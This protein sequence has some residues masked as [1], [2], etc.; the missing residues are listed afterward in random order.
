MFRARRDP[1]D[2]INKH[3]IYEVWGDMVEGAAEDGPM[4]IEAIRGY[5]ESSSLAEYFNCQVL[6]TKQD[7]HPF[8]ALQWDD[9]VVDIDARSFGAHLD[10]YAILALKR[11]LLDSPDPL[12][13][14]ADLEGWQRRDLQ[15]F[16]TLLKR[17][18]D[19]ALQMLDEGRV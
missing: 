3:D 11:G 6:E 4:V 19:E 14:I 17:A 5:L 9:M 18:M 13:R 10:V 12:A 8:L 1:G 16:Q 15:V 2:G 7:S